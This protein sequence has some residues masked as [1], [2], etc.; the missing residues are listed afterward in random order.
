M[1]HAALI[2]EIDAYCSRTGLSASTVCLRAVGN[3]HLP[4]RLKAGGQCLPRTA[5][6]VRAYMRDNPPKTDEAA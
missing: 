4:A 6:R 5:D 2:D 1:E 3:A